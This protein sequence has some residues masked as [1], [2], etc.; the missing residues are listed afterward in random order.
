[1]T[2]DYLLLRQMAWS[3]SSVCVRLKVNTMQLRSDVTFKCIVIQYRKRASMCRY[4]NRDACVSQLYSSVCAQGEFVS[5]V[6]SYKTSNMKF[7][8]LTRKYVDIFSLTV[9]DL[10]KSPSVC[11]SGKYPVKLFWTQRC[12]VLLQGRVLLNS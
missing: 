10:Q 1:M 11:R 7:R 4:A 3:Y 8:C 5:I 2:L 12:N 6:H 9:E